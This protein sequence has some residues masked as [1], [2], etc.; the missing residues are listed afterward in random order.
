VLR[1]IRDVA[2]QEPATI[3]PVRIARR[4]DRILDSDHG[5]WVSFSFDRLRRFGYGFDRF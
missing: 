4:I 2:V 1:A 3:D 5:R